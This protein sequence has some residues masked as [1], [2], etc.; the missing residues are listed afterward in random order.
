MLAQGA[1][2]C[3]RL[4]ERLDQVITEMDGETWGGDERDLVV[5]DSQGASMSSTR[6]VTGESSRALNTV[7]LTSAGMNHFRKVWLYA[8]SRLPPHMPPFKV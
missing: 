1:A 7:V 6:E 3:D 5:E 2:L 8:N 4:V